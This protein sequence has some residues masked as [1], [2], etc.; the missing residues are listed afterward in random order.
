M[1]PFIHPRES[2]IF[3]NGLI[4]RGFAPRVSHDYLALPMKGAAVIT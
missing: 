2:D 1:I 3:A 4:K